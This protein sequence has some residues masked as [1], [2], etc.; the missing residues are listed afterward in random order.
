MA[1]PASPVGHF[2]FL[3]RDDP[4]TSG[5]RSYHT[6]MPDALVTLTID[7]YLAIITLNDPEKRNALGIAMFDEL[8]KALALIEAD[9]ALRVILLRGEGRVFCAGFDLGRAVQKPEMMGRY[10][11]RLSDINRRIRRLGPVVVV[12]IQGAAIAGGCALLSACDFV[13]IAPDAKVGYPVHAIGVSPAVTIPTLQAAVGPGACRVLLLGGK[14]I[15][16]VE[17]KRIGLATHL[18][19]SGDSVHDEAIALCRLLTDKPPGALRVTKAWLN[20]LDGSLDDERFDPPARESGALAS[21]KE[22][23]D[24]LRAFWQSR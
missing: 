22:A 17:A 16:G 13:C 3:G 24:M 20:E 1:D 12:A 11:E 10:I 21:G 14:L 6:P 18:A 8:E 5:L 19:R 15:D 4:K 2:A 9:E 7:D 23:S